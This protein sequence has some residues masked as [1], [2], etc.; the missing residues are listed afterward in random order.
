MSEKRGFFIG[1]EYYTP[2]KPIKK[3]LNPYNG[4]T[5]SEIQRSW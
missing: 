4:R 2:E 3:I 5:V 1:G